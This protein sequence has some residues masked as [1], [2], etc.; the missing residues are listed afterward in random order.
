MVTA[1]NKVASADYSRYLI[2]DSL[3][4]DSIRKV[5]EI[6]RHYQESGVIIGS[7]FDDDIWL[8]TDEK[9]QTSIKFDYSETLFESNARRWVSCGFRGFKETAKAYI[10]FHMGALTLDHLRELAFRFGQVAASGYP[11]EDGYA[12]ETRHVR[13]FLMLLLGSSE[14]RD[15]A[16]E[17]LDECAPRLSRKRGNQR[18]LL[19]FPSYFRFHDAIN[20][21]WSAADMEKKLYYFPLYL[22]WELTA[23]LPLRVTEFLMLPVDC[24]SHNDG[25][26]CITVRR[27]RLKGGKSLMTYHIEDDYEKKTYPVSKHISDEV[28][29]YRRATEKMTPSKI[30]CLFS[31]DPFKG[32]HASSQVE[33]YSYYCL[34]KTKIDF[35]AHE[36]TGQDIPDVHLGDT[37]HIAMMNLI[38]SGGSPRICMELAGHANMAMSSHYYSNMSELVKCSTYELYRR[39]K[40]GASLMV[41]G[42]E[43]YSLEPADTLPKVAGGYCGSTAFAAGRVDDCILSMNGQGEI[44]ECTSCRHYRTD[45]QGMRLDFFDTDQGKKKVDYDSWFLMHMVEAVRQGI[46]CEENIKQAILRLQHSGNHYR[47]CLWKQ[48]MEGEHG[49]TK[50]SII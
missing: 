28:E 13:D 47:E 27:T 23:V 48:F 43:I 31:V 22:W 19:D 10:V 2:V 40:E 37:R 34:K 44:G 50:E 15:S 35:Y 39:N 18:K 5:R 14:I 42:S 21:F 32:E 1:A 12:E 38:I 9:K 17:C 16:I 11:D 29:W 30:G 36:L 24:I 4:E 46:G 3:D 49:K 45:L 26:D 7:E 41:N 33:I 25:G 20:E 6:Y 8:V